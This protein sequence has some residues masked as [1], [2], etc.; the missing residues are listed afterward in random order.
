MYDVI[1]R[2]YAWGLFNKTDL[3]NFVA[4]VGWITAEDY[5]TITGEDYT[6]A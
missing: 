5:K 3:R 1:K 6:D 4:N 2:Y